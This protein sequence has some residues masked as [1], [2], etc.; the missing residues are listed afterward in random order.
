MGSACGNCC[1]GENSD[2]LELSISEVAPIMMDGA[3]GVLG[4]KQMHRT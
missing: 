4:S 1:A 2:K 3:S